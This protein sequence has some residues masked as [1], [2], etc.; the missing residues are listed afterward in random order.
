MAQFAAEPAHVHVDR[1]R[2]DLAIET[3]DAFQQPI[4]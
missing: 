3:P 1:P 2:F 4:A